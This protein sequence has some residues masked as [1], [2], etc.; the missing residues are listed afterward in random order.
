MRLVIDLQGAQGASAERGIGRYSRELAMAMARAPRGH[1]VIITLNSALPHT[2][3]RLR[4]EFATVLPSCNIQLWHPPPG[5]AEKNNSALR[6]AVEILRRQFLASLRPDLVHVSSVFEGFQDD[7]VTC[8]PSSTPRLPQVATCYDLI[9][10]IRR[11]EY[12]DPGCFFYPFRHWYFRALQE[13]SLCDGLLAI[14]ESTRQ[15]AIDHL[16]FPQDRIFNVQAG[17]HGSFRHVELSQSDHEKLLARYGIKDPFILF[18]GANDIRKN[19]RGLIAAYAQLP[20]HLRSVH[21]LVIVGNSG[22]RRV[23]EIAAEH[24][25]TDSSL[26]II[27]FVEECDLPRLYSA[28]ALFIF[29]SLHEGFGLPA[30]EA[31]ACG[32]PVIAS[33]TTSLPEA[34]GRS[35]ALFDPADPADIA[36]LMAKV[37]DNPSFRAELMAY[38]PEQAARFTWHNSAERAWDGL[39]AILAAGT[40]QDSAP[41]IGTSVSR[42]KL[43]F[44]SPLL[45]QTGDTLDDSAALACALALH[46]DITLVNEAGAVTNDR[47]AA[48]FPCLNKQ[49][50]ASAASQFDRILYRIDNSSFHRFQFE[51][52]LE[53]APGVVALDDIFMSNY[54]NLLARDLD[55]SNSYRNA[56]YESH[57]YPALFLDETKGRAAS[58]QAFPCTLP[59][60]QGGIGAVVQSHHAKE[61]L[62]KYFGEEATAGVDVIPSRRDIIV[63]SVRIAARERLGIAPDAFVVAS[64]GP[65]SERT[66]PERLRRAW[67]AA[68]SPGEL[69]F[70]G[71]TASALRAKLEASGSDW[72]DTSSVRITGHLSTH[73]HR[74]WLAAV[75]VAVQ[76]SDKP[77]RHTVGAIADCL[78]AGVP[79]IINRCGFAAE[80]SDDPAVIIA[81]DDDEAQLAAAIRHL[82]GDPQRVQ[83]MAKAAREKA[84]RTL[85]SDIVVAQYRDSI[86]NAYACHN[87]SAVTRDFASLS[88]P[89][90]A[91]VPAARAVAATFPAPRGPRLLMDISELARH[92]SR[93]GIQ[94]VV[95][96]VLGRALLDESIELRAEAV[97]FDNGRLRFV[98]DAPLAILGLKPLARPEAIVDARRGDILLC[99]DLNGRITPEDLATARSLQLRGARLVLIL[100]DMLPICR[101]H[102]FPPQLVAAVCE[103]YLQMLKIS[104][105]VICISRAVADDLINWLDEEHGRR[106]RPL[107]IGYFHLGA[108]F[109]ARKDHSPLSTKTE[110]VIQTAGKIPTF[111]MVGTVEPRKGHH[112]TLAVFDQL[113]REGYE[114]N[115]VIVGK[116]GWHMD[117][118]AEQLRN[119]PALGKTLFWLESCTDTDLRALYESSSALIMAS[120]DEGFGLPIV[121]AYRSGLP[122]IARDIPVFREIAGTKATYFTGDQPADLATT[123]LDWIARHRAGTV[124]KP[125]PNDALTWDESYQQLRSVLFEDNWYATWTPKPAG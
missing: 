104:D 22:S 81:V 56:L 5:I 124:P 87:Q 48:C 125:G 36:Q 52:L 21:Q 66:Q 42:P 101:P 68:G 55:D 65:I 23:Q 109:S 122:V 107:R 28:C 32:A 11:H 58:V 10:L 31:M 76:L 83:A 61:L 43:A 67:Q 84:H 17:I 110:T 54:Q 1:E 34:I 41:R 39:E 113:W 118:F 93:S 100:Y 115:L 102:L 97:R 59:I 20:Q 95:R 15:E 78:A 47:L 98:H 53:T 25:V 90:D 26:A 88:L 50:F 8:T 70:V 29:P 2:A 30:A 94:R 63:Q 19:E 60:L 108:D 69:V 16:S 33:N 72:P 71:E 91:L 111:L 7:L 64:F 35:D 92:D 96:E 62:R 103:W 89:A 75:D 44:V 57:G 38:G 79:L 120:S 45:S 3:E 82:Y 37:L 112:Q 116:L 106:D 40:R 14:S 13:M 121:E 80:L 86:E 73:V 77:C 74:T 105:D 114:A 18:L 51:E 123:I 85:H 4:A 6:P 9:P 12:L 24:G 119:S 27:P 46:Y 99:I 49:Q 117:D